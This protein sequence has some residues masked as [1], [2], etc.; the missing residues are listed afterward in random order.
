[1]TDNVC[2]YMCE[3]CEMDDGRRERCVSV[4]VCV[5]VCVCVYVCM[6]VCMYVCAFLFAL[7]FT[8]K[9][10]RRTDPP[11]SMFNTTNETQASTQLTETTY[12][13]QLQIRRRTKNQPTRPG[14]SV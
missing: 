14:L 6:Y 5:C 2:V 8:V 13:D 4:Y 7:S 1:M 3:M 10:L 12:E 11:P 9:A